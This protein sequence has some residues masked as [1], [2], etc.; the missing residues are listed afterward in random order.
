VVDNLS[1]G[2]EKSLPKNVKFLKGDIRDE[3]FLETTFSE[4]KID[5]VMHFC[6]LS[7]V[8]NSIKDPLSYYD[9]NV[10]GTIRLLQSMIKHKVKN[11]IFSSTAAIFGEGKCFDIQLVSKI[12]IEPEDIKL[13]I[14]SYGETKLVVENMLKWCSNAYDFKFV[15]LRYFNASG[16]D[17]NGDIGEDHH[18]ETH[19]IPIILQVP[20]GKREKIMVFGDDYNT[21]DGTCIRD[22]IH[23]TDFSISTY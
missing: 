17:D 4:N 15:S 23:I 14:N 2:H 3:N 9:N 10:V 22:Y 8:S 6:A 19:L 11:F 18:P 12:P 20:L 13:P 5:Y 16:A 7:I 21:K 1:L